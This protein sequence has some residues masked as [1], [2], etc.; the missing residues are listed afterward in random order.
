MRGNSRVEDCALTFFFGWFF[1]FLFFLDCQCVRGR[2]HCAI[3]TAAI[4]Q[5][6]STGGWMTDSRIP[7]FVDEKVFKNLAC[8]GSSCTDHIT[9]F[10][11][12]TMP[13]YELVCIA[14][15]S[16]K[17]VGSR[18]ISLPLILEIHLSSHWKHRLLSRRS[19]QRRRVSFWP[20]EESCA[21]WITG[22]FAICPR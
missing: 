2:F 20:M 21:L 6:E 1:F 9:Q 13:L 18:R 4:R 7:K 10:P 8:P 11:A 14:A 5:T 15:Q 17:F 12:P 16:L 22:V 19:R 3:S